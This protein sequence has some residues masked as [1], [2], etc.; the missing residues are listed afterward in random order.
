[1]TR[2][3]PTCARCLRLVDRLEEE[4]DAFG[5]LILRAVCHGEVDRV[6]LEPGDGG[7]SDVSG[8]AFVPAGP[9]RLGA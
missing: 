4:V 7:P 1:M 6:V 5:R 2:A 8:V 3:R 9:A